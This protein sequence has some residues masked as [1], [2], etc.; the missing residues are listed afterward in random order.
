MFSFIKKLYQSKKT[1]YVDINLEEHKKLSNQIRRLGEATDYEIS[2]LHD[3]L[4]KILGYIRESKRVET[5]FP[6]KNK[7]PFDEIKKRH[8]L[9]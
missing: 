4:N 8:G 7:D 3:D 2:L 5:R 1:D 9:E 6:Q